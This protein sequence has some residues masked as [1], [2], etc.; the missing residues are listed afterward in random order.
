MTTSINDAVITEIDDL[1]VRAEKLSREA[2]RA[3][4][5]LGFDRIEE[6]SA[7]ANRGGQLIRRLYE[8][9]S[10]FL[11]SWRKVLSNKSFT[12]MHS[13]HYEHVSE[14]AGILRAVQHDVKSG[15]MRNLRGLLQAEIFA[16]FLEMAEHLLHEGYKDAAAV[17]LGAVLEDSLRKLAATH[18][19]PV[20][21]SGGKA[22]TIDPLNVALA[23]AGAYGPLVQ[24][25]ITT[26]AN[27][28]N[29]AA[30]GHFEKYDQDQVKQMLLF[31]Q[32]FCADYLG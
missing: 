25:Q 30:H 9:E 26:W 31:V 23:K 11:E 17:L 32:K 1:V 7:I 20:T 14:L 28:R 27:L 21:S 10:Q 5:G 29:D 8:A 13:N 19:V 16:D 24:K 18:N 22:L 12:N 3:G 2:S 6:L 15:L 4:S